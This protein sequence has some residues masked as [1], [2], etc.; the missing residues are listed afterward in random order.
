MASKK[1]VAFEG[2]GK[3]KNLVVKRNSLVRAKFRLTLIEQQIL[4]FGVC[5]AR[6]EQLGLSSDRPLVIDAL[7]FARQFGLDPANSY[8]QLKKGIEALGN[9]KLRFQAI[10]EASGLLEKG[11]FHWLEQGSY[12]DGKGELRL[13]FHKRVVPEIT[14]IVPQDGLTKGYT[15]YL[16]EKVSG[17][18]STHAVRLY[19]LLVEYR[20]IGVREFEV[21]WLREAFDLKD[22]EYPRLFDFKRKVIN[23]ALEQ[24]S[25][26]SDLDVE[27]YQK[28]SGHVVTDMGFKFSIKEGHEP[29][30]KQEPID[31]ALI[32]KSARPGETRDQTYERLKADRTSAKAKKKRGKATDVAP[33]LALDL[34]ASITTE[35][36]QNKNDPTVKDLRKQAMAAS[37][38]LLSSSASRPFASD[39]Q[40]RDVL[41]NLGQQRLLPDSDHEKPEDK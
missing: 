28:K 26:H 30:E 41:E 7:D 37:R 32:K 6:E 23:V 18:T 5:K 11:F 22:G 21:S 1:K 16:L 38:K 25:L 15:K 27:Y 39:Q 9:R 17:M 31:D 40:V 13:V 4:L 33:N 3:G 34:P 2:K 29:P 10:D 14:R 20:G 35:V 19:E 8:R 24:I 12:I 36:V